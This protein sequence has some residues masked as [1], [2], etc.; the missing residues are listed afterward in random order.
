MSAG[1]QHITGQG[2]PVAGGVK[3][4]QKPG[5][6]LHPLFQAAAAMPHQIPDIEKSLDDLITGTPT[7][8]DFDFFDIAVVFQPCQLGIDG[9]HVQAGIS[10]HLLGGDRVPI[11]CHR[12]QHGAGLRRGFFGAGFV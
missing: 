4:T 3:P 7:A 5:Q 10:R 12:V 6:P 8:A 2:F 9:S 11:Q 1:T